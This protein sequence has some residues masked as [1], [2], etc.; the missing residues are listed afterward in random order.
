MHRWIVCQHRRAAPP[1]R[2]QYNNFAEHRRA[3]DSDREERHG[4]DSEHGDKQQNKQYRYGQR[5]QQ[6]GQN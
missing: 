4:C 5:K 3:D 2:R 6:C 1:D